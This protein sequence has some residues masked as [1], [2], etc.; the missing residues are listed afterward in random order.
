MAMSLPSG[1]IKRNTRMVNYLISHAHEHNDNIRQQ[2]GLMS[3]MT[4]RQLG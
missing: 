2:E 1:D 3:Y 4:G